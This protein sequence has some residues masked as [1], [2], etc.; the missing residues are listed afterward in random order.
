[1]GT[2]TVKWDLGQKMLVRAVMD[3][4]LY[5]LIDNNIYVGGFQS[6]DVIT[7]RNGVTV[8]ASH[9]HTRQHRL[10]GC[11]AWIGPSCFGHS[12][13][14]GVTVSNNAKLHSSWQPAPCNWKAVAII[15]D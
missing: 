3:E 4:E 10:F 14:S 1:M 5:E 15:V 11:T 6:T 13:T 8:S 12:A 2:K 7:D 9:S